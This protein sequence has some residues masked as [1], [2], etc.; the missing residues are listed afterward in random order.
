MIQYILLISAIACSK[1]STETYSN[2]TPK[3]KSNLTKHSLNLASAA[4]SHWSHIKN[5]AFIHQEKAESVP[6]GIPLFIKDVEKAEADLE[7]VETSV[8]KQVT[9]LKE[10]AKAKSDALLAENKRAMYSSEIDET[11]TPDE[12]IEEIKE[13]EEIEEEVEEEEEELEEEETEE[14]EE[15]EI[16]E[17]VEVENPFAHL[18][19]REQPWATRAGRPCWEDIAVCELIKDRCAGCHP[20]YKFRPTF[21]KAEKAVL[22]RMGSMPPTAPI[23][24]E[25]QQIFRDYFTKIRDYP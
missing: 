18:P 12:A 17:K 3:D 2:R 7:K 24:K 19:Y 1:G 4:P 8:A 21:I 13:A 22:R 20:D 9:I 23:S 14:E 11:V 6:F 15:V 10:T 25:Q 5:N 16:D